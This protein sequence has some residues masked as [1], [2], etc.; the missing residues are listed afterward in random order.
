M[1]VG[2]SRLQ[3]GEDAVGDLY[4][5]DVLEW[6][7]RQAALLRQHAAGKLGNE[8]PDWSNIIEEVESVGREQLHQVESLLAQA[9][10]HM[11]KAE[12]WPLSGEV[13]SWLADSRRFRDDAARRFTPSMRQRINLAKIYRQALRYLPEAIDGTA[14]LPVPEVCPVT[15]DELLAED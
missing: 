13:P 5:A 6:S 14:P 7:E 15:L 12:A 4:E 8:T 10:A 9:L 11:L 3:A 2:Q 1:L